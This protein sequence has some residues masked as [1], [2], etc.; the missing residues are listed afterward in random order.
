MLICGGTTSNGF[1]YCFSLIG[2]YWINSSS[3][4]RNTTAPAVEATVLPTSNA[5][6]VTCRGN[7]SLCRRSSTRWPIPRTRLLPP[8]LKI[9]LIARGLSRLLDGDTASLSRA[10]AKCARARSSGFMLLSSI[11]LLTCFCQLR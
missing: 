10:N 6:L 5:C 1:E 9:S 8:E 11:Q 7:P 4:L 2:L 3:S